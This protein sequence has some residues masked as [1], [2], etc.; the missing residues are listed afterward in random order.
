VDCPDGI[1][2][3]EYFTGYLASLSHLKPENRESRMG[4]VHPFSRYLN[5]FRPESRVMPLRMLPAVARS[6]RFCRITPDEVGV[7]MDVAGQLSPKIRAACIR[8]LIGLLY[9]TGL[10]ISEAINL[11]LG[12]VDLARSTL[13]V[14]RGKFG[15]DRLVALAPST[16][17]ALKTWLN[18]R[19]F[20][21]GNGNS[22]PLL[23]SAPDK[24]LSYQQAKHAFTKLRAQCELPGNPPPRLHDLRHNYASECLARWRREGKDIQTLLPILS[25]AMGHV[26]PRSTQ[27]YVHI[28]AATLLDASG[29]IHDRFIQPNGENQ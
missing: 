8:F 23:V 10:R 14:H 1:L 17:E 28:D 22:A 26:N 25:A 18:L 7:L 4:V 27:R 21:A 12:D 19:S 9:T 13:F 3:S 5:A 16:T 11:N 24:R 20:H 15:K 29:K 6:I 2:H